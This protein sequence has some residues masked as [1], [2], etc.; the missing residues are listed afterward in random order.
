MPGGLEARRRVVDAIGPAHH[1]A[2][3]EVIREPEARPPVVLVGRRLPAV[4]FVDEADRAP[5]RVPREEF[6]GRHLIGDRRERLEIEDA[7]PVEALGA[8]HVEVVAQ[9]EG[10]RQFG[11]PSSCLRNTRPSK[12]SP[13]P[14]SGHG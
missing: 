6:V 8:R 5:Q 7:V 3:P 1:S 14:A 2:V 11:K 4:V 9:P 10:E 13:R 12:G